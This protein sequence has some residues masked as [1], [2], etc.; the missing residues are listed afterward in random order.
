MKK[1]IL[2]SALSTVFSHSAL[3]MEQ[4]E[5]T[6][7]LNGFSK[8][9]KSTY[10]ENGTRHTYNETNPGL[11][12]SYAYRDHLDIRV[13]GFENSYHRDSVYAGI[14]LHKDY[15]F[16]DWTIAPGLNVFLI[17]GYENRTDVP[18]IL[19]PSLTLGHNAVKINIGILPF[20]DEASVATFQL[21]LNFKYF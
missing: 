19:L 16:G 2:I 4:G 14:H 9:S 12:V 1:Y 8:H 5:F 17:S 20:G 21:Q 3:A 13:G 15:Y 18:A 7:D 6:L 10:L 11:G